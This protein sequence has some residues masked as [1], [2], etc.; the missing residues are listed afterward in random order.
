MQL[1][2]QVMTPE[3]LLRDAVD[4]WPQFDTEHDEV[5]GADLVE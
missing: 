3:R 4:T 1:F 2:S 5:S